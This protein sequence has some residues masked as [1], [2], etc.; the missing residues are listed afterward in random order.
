MK[1]ILVTGAGGFIG[2]NLCKHLAKDGFEVVGVDRHYPDENKRSDVFKM[3]VGDFRNTDQ[4][5]SW[6]S[7]VD[8]VIHLASAHLQISLNADEYWSINVHSLRPFLEQSRNLGVQRFIHVSSV[9]VYGNLTVLPADE[10]TSCFPQSIYGQT[11]LAGEREVLD[12][13]FESEFPVVVLR[14]AWVFGP[15]C[16]R[17][18]KIY[19]TLWKKR[20]VMIGNGENLRHPIYIDD[21]ISATK[22]CMLNDDAIGEVFIVAGETA[23][24]TNE[25][26]KSFY[27]E[28]DLPKPKIRIPYWFGSLLA[29]GTEM[30]FGVMG[31]EPPVSKRSLEFFNTNNAFSI[32]KAEN[33][34]GYAS[35]YSFEE[36]LKRCRGW[37]EAQVE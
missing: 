7:G 33:V 2:Y 3:E 29:Q 10:T 19:R 22:L 27:M 16:P 21:M 20:F 34:L 8:A 14:P 30:V 6:L 24:T 36:G 26:I 15:Y 12:F 18:L 5:N 32:Q 28:M 11:K 1:K 4:M 17:T 37:L 23:I 31:K 9:G 13:A 25:L 35:E